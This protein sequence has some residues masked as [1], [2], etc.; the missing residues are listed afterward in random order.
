[1]KKHVEV[2]LRNYIWCI[3]RWISTFCH[4]YNQKRECDVIFMNNTRLE[5]IKNFAIR[6][7][8]S[9]SCK[10]HHSHIMIQNNIIFF[11]LIIKVTKCWNSSVDTLNNTQYKYLAKLQHLSSLMERLRQ[12]LVSHILFGVWFLFS[13]IKIWILIKIHH[14]NLTTSNKIIQCLYYNY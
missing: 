14:T 5:V 8:K 4:F 2:L 9:T 7:V 12:K 13:T 1:M 6:N 11:F 3:N 10:M